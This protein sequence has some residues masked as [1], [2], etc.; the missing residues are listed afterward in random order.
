MTKVKAITSFDH[1]NESY[2]AGEE[3]DVPDVSARELATAKLVTIVADAEPVKPSNK[4]TPDA[5]PPKTVTHG[6]VS[7]STKDIG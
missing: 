1:S 6:N 5:V 3:F 7:R 2:Q 4:M